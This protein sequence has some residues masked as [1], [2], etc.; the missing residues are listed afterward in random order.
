M[1]YN[2][3]RTRHT[4]NLSGKTVAITGSTG[5]LGKA[6]CRDL[7]ALGASL[8]LMD[9]NA[10][11]SEAHRAELLA[12]FP[13]LS[14]RTLITELENMASVR[15]AAEELIGCGVDIFIHNAGAY[16]IPRHKCDTGYENLFQINFLSPYYLI[17]RLLPTLR[18]RGGRVVV[19]GSIAHNYSKINPND[20]DFSAHKKPSRAYGN[21]KRHLM[22][23][24]Y[25]LWQEEQGVTLAVTHPGIAVT[26]ITS[27]YPKVI[28]ALIKLPMKL[29]FM[30]PKKA[31]LSIL[32]GVFDSCAYHEWI[33][34][35][36][37]NVW[38]MPKKQ[39]LRTCTP[40][41][42]RQIGDFAQAWYTQTANHE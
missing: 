41:E 9:R 26:G 31:S 28:Y 24:L 37:F 21:A 5:G 33:G 27:H 18:Q 25:E 39:R 11:R 14:V 12:L 20:R 34:P 42:S 32:Q 19:V 6:L 22:F 40:E 13:S 30:K 29:I 17:R 8:I 7:A 23:S 1:S 35:R 15:S 4:S 36:I 38:G 16:G 10:S 2:T 3:W